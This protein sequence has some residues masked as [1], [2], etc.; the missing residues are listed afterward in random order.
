MPNITKVI[1][2]GWTRGF[3]DAWALHGKDRA[4]FYNCPNLTTVDFGIIDV[5]FPNYRNNSHSPLFA[6]CSNMTT[7]IIRNTSVL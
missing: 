7:L 3:T 6:D 4:F 2:G 5:S 1:F